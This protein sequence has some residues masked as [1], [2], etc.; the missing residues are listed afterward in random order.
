MKFLSA[1]VLKDSTATYELFH[2]V[3]GAVNRKES[4][5]LYNGLFLKEAHCSRA[6]D[7]CNLAL[8]PLLSARF[9]LSLPMPKKKMRTRLF[10]LPSPSL[11]RCTERLHQFRSTSAAS[12]RKRRAS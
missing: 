7:S 2:C 1:R 11:S 12:G 4:A 8:P 6:A 3:P 5:V 9:F 10:L